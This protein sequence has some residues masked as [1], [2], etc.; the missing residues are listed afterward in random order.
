MLF[1]RESTFSRT[2]EMF[3]PRT[4]F[5]SCFFIGM[6]LHLMAVACANSRVRI[7]GAGAIP[8]SAMRSP[9]EARATSS[10]SIPESTT[11]ASCSRHVTIKAAVIGPE[12]PQVTID[13]SSMGRHFLIRQYPGHL[14]IE[15]IRLRN[16][17]VSGLGPLAHD[18]GSIRK[19][20]GRT[21]SRTASSSIVLRCWEAVASNRGDRCCR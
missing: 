14:F 13:A 2:A 18:G 8:A 6:A 15:G 5:Y 20:S 16:G 1:R 3:M 21:T 9:L 12:F 7:V 10:R 4:N 17:D 11:A 19:D